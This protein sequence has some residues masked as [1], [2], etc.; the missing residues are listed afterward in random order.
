MKVSPNQVLRAS[1]HMNEVNFGFVIGR[2]EG[3]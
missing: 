2:E 1:S 3:E